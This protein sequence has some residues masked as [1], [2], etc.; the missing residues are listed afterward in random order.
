MSPPTDPSHFRGRFYQDIFLN[1]GAGKPMNTPITKYL[2]AA[3]EDGSDTLT[4]PQVVEGEQ[5]A[6]AEVGVRA[7]H[8]SEDWEIVA[9]PLLCS[10][11]GGG[12]RS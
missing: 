9:I 3:I 10:R 2:V 7:A 4:E 11:L 12:A 8:L 6:Y 5:E 1:K